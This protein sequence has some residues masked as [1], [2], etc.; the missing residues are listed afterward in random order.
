[1]IISII[2][3][4]PTFLNT[5]S[6]MRTMVRLP[7]WD[8]CTQET[9]TWHKI[10]QYDSVMCTQNRDSVLGLGH[11]THARALLATLTRSCDP[12]W[13]SRTR[14][15]ASRALSCDTR[16]GSVWVSSINDIKSISSYLFFLGSK[17]FSWSSKKQK[18][19]PCL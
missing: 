3:F 8:M 11:L 7:D 6:V 14:S 18:T 4:F 1:M 2:F 12:W 15:R 17:V 16:W 13:G 19:M 10:R 5:L 9:I